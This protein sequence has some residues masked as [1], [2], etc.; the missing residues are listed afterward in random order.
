M[1]KYFVQAQSAPPLPPPVKNTQ[2]QSVIS[3]AGG[4]QLQRGVQRTGSKVSSSSLSDGDGHGTAS[5]WKVS[6][7]IQQ[8]LDTL[9]KPKRRPLPE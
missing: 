2:R 3:C 4:G 5:R 8:L 7:K 9:R 1:Q 6:A